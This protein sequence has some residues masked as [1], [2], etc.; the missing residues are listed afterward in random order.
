MTRS[1][2][3]APHLG[4]TEL[5]DLLDGTLRSDRLA[6]ADACG[7]CRQ[8]VDEL[9]TVLRTAVDVDVPEPPDH[10]WDSLSA[11]VRGAV[12]EEPT[13]RGGLWSRLAP[14]PVRWA[15]LAATAFVA[16]S[17]SVW[18]GNDPI[19]PSR[20]EPGAPVASVRTSASTSDETFVDVEADEAWALVRSIADDVELENMGEAGIALGPGSSEDMVT[21][22]TDHERQELARLVEEAIASG[23]TSESSL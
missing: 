22:L 12:A 18:R 14:T 19:A 7:A 21:R 11:R 5:V 4:E 3:R 13:P 2:D 1:P 20:I 9:R 8:R 17:L 23:P 15:A 6:H 10:F 16:I